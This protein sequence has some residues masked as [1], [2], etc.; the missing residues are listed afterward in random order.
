V[1]AGAT[2]GERSYLRFFNRS[3]ESAIATVRIYNFFDGTEV[4][5]VVTAEIPSHASYQYEITEF[6]S[7]A[8][9]EGAAGDY[10]ALSVEPDFD[11]F[12]Q[13]VYWNDIGQSLTNITGCAT[14]ASNNNSVILNFHTSNLSE[15]YP[16]TALFH[17]VGSEPSDLVMN[18]YDA[19]TGEEI[20]SLQY[21][22]QVQPD[23][24]VGFRSEGLDSILFDL[25]GHEPTS[26]QYHYNIE[27]IGEF[28]GYAQHYVENVG[29]G[30]TT[31]MSTTC[32][33]V[34]E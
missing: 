12:F 29:S 2:L 25:Y 21:I 15:G 8:G 26:Q 24:A 6:E 4:G 18:V 34:A 31:N 3:A 32:D 16:S 28:S 19:V 14:G 11:G 20:G 22:G 27:I 10:Y 33:L 1:S 9:I 23:E 5:A 30:V 7:A 17:N 13:H